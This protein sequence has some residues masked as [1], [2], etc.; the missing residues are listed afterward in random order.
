MSTQMTFNYD[1]EWDILQS[2]GA[3]S[4]LLNKETSIFHLLMS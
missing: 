4:G 3:V 2:F 1:Y